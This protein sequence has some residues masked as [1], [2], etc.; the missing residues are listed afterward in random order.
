MGVPEFSVWK[1]KQLQSVLARVS[2]SYNSTWLGAELEFMPVWKGSPPWQQC[3]VSQRPETSGVPFWAWVSFLLY[4]ACFLSSPIES[5]DR[6]SFW[7]AFRLKEKICTCRNLSRRVIIVIILSLREYN[8]CIFSKWEKYWSLNDAA[9]SI[10]STSMR[11][12]LLTRGVT[13]KSSL[14]IANGLILHL[15]SWE[16]MQ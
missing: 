16:A 6:L 12:N 13:N 10:S 4:R 15:C 7:R 9:R 14:I 1:A 8:H 3:F 11:I 5:I 2:W